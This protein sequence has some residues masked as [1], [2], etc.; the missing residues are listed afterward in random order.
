MATKAKSAAKAKEQL[1]GNV[2][3]FK[4]NAPTAFKL[5]EGM[6]VAR[7]VTMP[8]LV[9]KEVNEPRC[10]LVVSEMRVSTVKG[11]KN[12]DGTYEKPA[13]VCDV[14][15]IQT[16]EQMVFLVPAVVQKNLEDMYPNAE[17]VGKTFYI[18]NLGKRKSGQRYNDFKIVELAA[19]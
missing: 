11:K 14:G 18:E 10:L 4:S 12:A 19:E 2:V 16:G 7:V 17:Y 1:T 9:M 3:E 6:R 13:T 8:S 5:P 15:D